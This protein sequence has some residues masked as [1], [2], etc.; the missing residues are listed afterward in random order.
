MFDLEISNSLWLSQEPAKA[1]PQ[2]AFYEAL[3]TSSCSRPILPSGPLGELEA[4]CTLSNCSIEASTGPK[5]LS[6]KW[7]NIYFS[8]AFLRTATSEMFYLGKIVK[9]ANL[10]NMGI[11]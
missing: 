8:K 9:E 7:A 10:P 3:R 4:A 2:L 11:Q 6:L 1:Q 5:G